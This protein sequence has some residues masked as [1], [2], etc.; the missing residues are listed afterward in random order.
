MDPLT[1]DEYRRLLA[2][3]GYSQER[4]AVLVGANKRTGQKWA[5]G[6]ARIP[7]AAALIL[8]LLVLRPEIKSVIEGMGPPPPRSRSQK[9]RRKAKAQ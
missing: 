5:L 8:R 7:G 2:E 9:P 1:P 3:V 6:E 4:F